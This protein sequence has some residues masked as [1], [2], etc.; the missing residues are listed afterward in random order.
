MDPTLFD[1]C[2]AAGGAAVPERIWATPASRGV[3][4][5]DSSAVDSTV[6][7]IPAR[8]T[9]SLRQAEHTRQQAERQTSSSRQAFISRQQKVRIINRERN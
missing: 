7:P 6:Q 3:C 5:Q 8:Q 4:R 1:V 9:D 2:I